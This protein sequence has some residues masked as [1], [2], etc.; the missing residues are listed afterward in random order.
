M[1]FYPMTDPMVPEPDHQGP[2]GYEDEH[3]ALPELDPEEYHPDWF[4]V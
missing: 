4:D 1:T 2:V 3:Q